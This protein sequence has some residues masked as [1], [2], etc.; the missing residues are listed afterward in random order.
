MRAHVA[1]SALLLAPAAHAQPGPQAAP[2]VSPEVL[3]DRRVVFRIRA[4]QA[5]VVRLV[6]SDIPGVGQGSPLSTDGNGVWVAT[7]GP[8]EPGT[9][10]YHFNVDGVPV[11]DPRNPTTSESNNNTWSLVYVPGLD[12]MDTR[13][14]PHGAVAAVTY[15]SSALGR[16]RRMH[17]YTPPGYPAGGGKYPVLYL[18]HGAGDSDDS[19]TSVG[20]AGFILDNLIADKKAKPMIVVMPAGHTAPGGFRQPTRNDDFSRDF[21]NDV[22]PYVE[23][24][25]R[26]LKDRSQRAIA[27]LSMGGNQ[28][29]DIAVSH[30]D[31]FGY[32]GV[33]SSGLIG[34]FGP[35]RSPAPGAPSPS[36]SPPGPTWEEQHRKALDDASRRKGLELLW[37]ATGKEDFLLET[38]RKTVVLFKRHG[39]DPVYRET[40]GGHTWI[41]WR[42]YLNEFA[43][44]LFR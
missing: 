6:G 41:N 16:F 14:V 19:W 8:I 12:F 27:G 37:F 13:D 4:P 17:I 10:R 26:L 43:P 34:M 1:L 15:Y 20:R 9:Y 36:P 32:V 23:K 3:G 24:N 44:L 39:F 18:L 22:V 29:L 5:Q 30:L 25:Y 21:L 28:S 33:Y 7:L 2:V 38:T 40:G 31:R 11:I 42:Q 35:V